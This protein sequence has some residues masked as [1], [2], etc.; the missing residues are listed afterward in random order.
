MDFD[1]PIASR[2]VGSSLRP[3]GPGSAE[4][5]RCAPPAN[6]DSATAPT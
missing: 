5:L 2:V 6:L 3:P 4:V 1:L